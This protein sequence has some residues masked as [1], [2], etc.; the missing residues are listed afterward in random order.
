ME[1]DGASFAGVHSS[2]RDIPIG[3]EAG[4]GLAYNLPAMR[5]RDGVRGFFLLTAP[6]LAVFSLLSGAIPSASTSPLETVRNLEKKLAALR[7]LQ[8]DFEQAYFPASIATPLEEKGRLFIE[9]PERMRWE[10]LE[11]EPK[12]YLYKEGLSLAYFPE[13]KQLFRYS[14]M[15]EEE[16]SPIMS[17]LAG[18]SRI[19]DEYLVEPGDESGSGSDQGLH[20]VR[21]IPRAEGEFSRIL[22][23][24]DK[25]T[26]L[27]SEA[28]FTD[29]AGNRQAFRFRRIRLNPRFEPG[30][31][32]LRVPPD[33]EIIDDRPAE[34]K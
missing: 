29:L 32:D 20:G 7:T 26:W 15:P 22:L 14:P 5:I 23:R 11:P 12:I 21:L 30:I 9:R 4:A 24:I 25:K 6:C 16:N 34:K 17:L 3:V 8:A 18:R 13:D 2:N 31:F 10:Y 33:T 19:E 27:I 1:K 28:E